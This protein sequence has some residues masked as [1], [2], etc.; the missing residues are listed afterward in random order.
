QKDALLVPQRAVM[1]MQGGYQVAVVDGAN[2]VSLR[3]VKPGARYGAQWIIEDGLKPNERVVVEGTDK[4]SPGIQ[5]SPKG[6]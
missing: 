4:V 6:T 1:E 2:R 3:A 5:V